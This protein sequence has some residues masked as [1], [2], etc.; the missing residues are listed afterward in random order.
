MTHADSQNICFWTGIYIR[1]D[2]DRTIV[3]RVLVKL[4]FLLKDPQVP[5]SLGQFNLKDLHFLILY[6]GMKF[7]YQLLN[8]F[9]VKRFFI[10]KVFL[11]CYL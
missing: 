4:P 2:N 6:I 5:Y 8:H 9:Y 1:E 3:E 11:K 10:S 7:P